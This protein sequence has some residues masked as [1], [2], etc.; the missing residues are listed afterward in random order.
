MKKKNKKKNK[1]TAKIFL[2][3]DVFGYHVKQPSPWRDFNRTLR[4]AIKYFI[5][6]D[7][8]YA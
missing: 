2:L 1:Q 7:V 8:A 3:N 6:C 5:H 4:P